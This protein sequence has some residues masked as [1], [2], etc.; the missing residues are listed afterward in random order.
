MKRFALIRIV[1]GC[2]AALIAVAGCGGGNDAPMPPAPAPTVT[3]PT[4]LTY[5]S[6]STA[7]LNAALSLTPTVSGTVTTYTVTPALPA[8]LALNATSGAITGSATSLVDTATYTVT[9]T[10]SAGSTTFPLS[11]KVG[12][13]TATAYVQSNLVSNGAIAGTRTDAKLVNPWG[14]AFGAAGPGWISDNGSNF[15]TLYDG[16]GIASATVVAIPA[17]TRG[18][19]EPTGIVANATTDFTV[20]KTGVTAAARF[21]FAGEGG[22]IAAWSP[23][24]D[25][26]NAITTY[27]DGAGGAHYEGLALAAN[28]T[29]NTLYATDFKNRKVD[30][31]DKNFAKI[32][33]TGGFTDPNLP[34][35]YAPY[36]IQA[37]TLGTTTVLVV[38]YASQNTAATDA[39]IGAG[40]GLVD[41]FDLNG[42]LVR[43]LVSPGGKL[44][45]PWGVAKAPATFGS[46]SNLLLI[47]NFG[48]GVINAY[49]PTTGVFGASI[50]AGGGTP[51]ANVGLWGIQFG[52]GVQNQSTSTLYF[53]AGISGE[54]AGLY[55]RIDLGATAPDVV[56]PTVAVT[57]PAAASTVSGTI[58]VTANAAD[59][60]GI[61]Q[62]VFQ[63]RVGTTTTTIATVKVAPFTANLDTTTVA[64][65]AASLLA[66]ATDTGGNVTTS[67]AIAVTVNNVPTVPAATTLATLQTSIFTPIC[68]TCHTGVGASLSGSMNL[69]SATT[70]FAAL[71]GVTSSEV[72]SLKRVTAGDPAN[73]YIIQKLEGTQ[74]V[75]SRMPLGGPFLSQAQI[76]TVKSWI[77]AGAAP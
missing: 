57:A 50:N 25:A 40:L 11:L 77:Q 6:P 62:V 48:D 28:G 63:V 74:T 42:T 1:A 53:T 70:S 21:I 20:T 4:G 60:V 69:T 38:T 59:N 61:A 44:N 65:G 32:T 51:L 3:A 75:G 23:T 45:A 36:G 31:F 73:S 67:A 56:A 9:A 22:T 15:S 29:A 64:N 47:G 34:A 39:V 5:T 71:V 49:D 35:G 18:P 76:D 19:A 58:A 17:S 41:I 46:L 26:A 16:T 33:A 52:N 8:G 54:T 37:V 68:S 14:L 72:A 10:N 13:P 43:R 66:V 7:T 55:G 30:V 27:D 12:M 2:A 24:V